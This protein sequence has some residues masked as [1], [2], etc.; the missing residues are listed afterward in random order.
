[1]KKRKMIFISIIIVII[2]AMLVIILWP[3]YELTKQEEKRIHKEIENN[4]NSITSEDITLDKMEKIIGRDIANV[5]ITVGENSYLRNRPSNKI[6][7]K[8]DLEELVNKEEKLAKRV[9]ERYENSLEYEITNREVNGNEMCEDVRISTY[10]YALYLID[11]INLTNEIAGN[12]VE[13][14]SQDVKLEIKF[15]ESQ[16]KAM[17]I[18]DKHLD[19]YE[20]VNKEKTIQRVCYK[21]GKTTADTML[22][23]VVAL[24]GET[25]SN[26]DFSKQENIDLANQRLQK[27]LNE[28]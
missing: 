23:L 1:M 25:Y 5:H 10:Y 8:Y 28:L 12:P 16:V 2:I 6:I 11:L 15:F 20:N 13:D 4:I 19:D 9:E 7:K 26:C 17:E 3:K 18:L 22:S 27:Y 24:Q 21:S 14:V